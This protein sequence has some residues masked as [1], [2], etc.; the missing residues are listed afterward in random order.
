VRNALY[1]YLGLVVCKFAM[2][3]LGLA[4]FVTDVRGPRAAR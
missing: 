3:L 1:V 4:L 2:A